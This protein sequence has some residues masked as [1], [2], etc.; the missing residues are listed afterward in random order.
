MSAGAIA[1]QGVPGA[2]SEQAARDFVDGAELLAC[3]R[4]EDLFEAVSSGRARWGAVP[5]ENTL[6]GSVHACYDLLAR[7]TVTVAA[8]S[9]LRISHALIAPPGAVL[10]DIRRVLSHPMALIQCERFFQKNPGIE[11]VAVQDTAAAAEEVISGGRGDT[12]AI[13][14]LRAAEVYGGVVL[15]E[16]LED[17]PM[18]FTRFLLISRPEDRP[19]EQKKGSRPLKTSLLFRV[20]NR[21]AALF[22]GLRPFALRGI[23]LTKIESRPVRGSRFEYLFYLDAVVPPEREEDLDG[24]IEAL[25]QSSTNL[26]RLGTY[27]VAETAAPL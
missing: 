8:E 15:A 21:P 27:P 12:A 5:I 3:P 4:F 16:S 13:A 6:A 24:A 19:A 7:H 14:S 23:N 10:E 26:R 20:Q 11:A 9:V 1:Y 22:E 17:D 2:F 25:A 18:N